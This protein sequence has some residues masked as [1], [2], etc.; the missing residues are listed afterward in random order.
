MHAVD[1]DQMTLN[2]QGTI[3]NHA[4]AEMLSS[5]GLV[6]QIANGRRICSPASGNIHTPSPLTALNIGYF[7]KK[8]AM[9]PL[10]RVSTI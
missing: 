10:S 4:A 6:C 5:Q 3:I 1:R 7:S 8:N 9:R 2:G